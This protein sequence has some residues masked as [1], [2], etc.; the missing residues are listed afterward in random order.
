M[1]KLKYYWTK[2]GK[3]EFFVAVIAI[4]CVGLF[5]IGFNTT[6]N[7]DGAVVEQ[8]PVTEEVVEASPQPTEPSSQTPAT[9]APQPSTNV[10]KDCGHTNEN[11]A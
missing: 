1:E 3:G 8:Q 6:S 9:S 11:D 5:I 10:Y 4:I 2:L 7:N